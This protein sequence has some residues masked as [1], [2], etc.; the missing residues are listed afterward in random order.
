MVVTKRWS[1]FVSFLSAEFGEHARMVKYTTHVVGVKGQWVRASLDVR[2]EGQ[3]S[4]SHL[5]RSTNID[6]L[7]STRTNPANN[8]TAHYKKER[9]YSPVRLTLLSAICMSD[10]GTKGPGAS[11]VTK[12]PM[13][14]EE[15]L[16]YL[17]VT[18]F[19]ARK[20]KGSNNVPLFTIRVH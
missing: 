1:V 9:G 7:F 17:L 18:L 10:K 6:I 13:C 4:I 3:T 5:M 14:C 15:S 12:W 11:D 8:F 19:T 2:P 16:S 20:P